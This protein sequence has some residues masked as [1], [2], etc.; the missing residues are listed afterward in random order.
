MSGVDEEKCSS[1]VSEVMEVTPLLTTSPQP[2]KT[3]KSLR[4]LSSRVESVTFKDEL[5]PAPCPAPSSGDV[6]SSSLATAINSLLVPSPCKVTSR[7]KDQGQADRS[8][9]GGVG[10]HQNGTLP[11]CLPV[12]QPLITVTINPLEKDE[13]TFVP[14]SPMTEQRGRTLMDDEERK[15]SIGSASS[16]DEEDDANT[17]RLA[18]R[19][20]RRVSDI[21]HINELRREISGLSHLASEY[22][23]VKTTTDPDNIS[24]DSIHVRVLSRCAKYQVRESKSD[25]SSR[26]FV[27]ITT[28]LTII[29]ISCGFWYKNFSGLSDENHE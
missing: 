21:S 28:S 14:P 23:E 4:Q 13:M 25:R 9:A 8:L 20:I 29:G 1:D 24:L 2:V 10:R 12:C 26:Y 11:P 15:L 22:Y 27:I 6:G 16:F 7:Q 18:S 17:L 5:C 19:D 3:I